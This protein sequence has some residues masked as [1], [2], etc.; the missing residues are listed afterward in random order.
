MNKIVELKINPEVDLLGFEAVALVEQPA[1]EE[2]FYAFKSIDVQDLIVEEIIKKELF[3]ERLPGESKDH[4]I[5]RCIPKLKSEGYADDQAAAICYEGLA[6]ECPPA[7]QD[8]SLNLENRQHAIDTAHYG[9]LNPNE[10][11]EEYWKKKA[12]MFQSDITSAKKALCGNCSFFNQTQKILDCIATGI[13]QGES[14]SDPWSTID[15][16]DLGYC[17][18]FDFK[19]AANRTC[20]AWVVGGPITD[21][22]TGESLQE[23]KISFDF[24]DTLNTPEGKQLASDLIAKG[25]DVYVISAGQHVEEFYPIAD[26]LGIPH[27]KLFATGSNQA[28]IEKI[29]EL[30]IEKHYDNNEDVIYALG[31]IGEQFDLL[32]D[33]LPD[34]INE[35][36]D[37]TSYEFESYVDYPE[38]A[39][40]AAKR[41]LEW[42]DNHPEQGCGTLVGWARANQLAK[43]EPISEETIA[44]MASF[45]RHLQYEDVPYSEGCGGLMVDAWGGR[46]GIEWASR[47]LE[48]LRQ[49]NAGVDGLYYDDLD[50]DTQ[51]AIINALEGIGIA[52]ED[53]VKKGY[54]FN[55][56]KSDANPELPSRDTFGDYKI[57]YKYT[58]PKD[59]KN[60][61]FCARLLSLNL[62]FRKEDIQ[63]LSVKGAN[64]Q[65]GFY[66]IFMYKGSYNCRHE[67]TPVEVYIKDSRDEAIAGIVAGL[68]NT[69][70]SKPVETFSQFKFAA[71]QQILIGPM[72][73]PDKLILRI[74][75]SGNP[76]HIFF[77]R[78]TIKQIAYKMLKEKLI[79]K[80][81][82]EHNAANTVS[83][84]LL[85]SWII[86]DPLKDK[87]TTYGFSLP[88]GTWMAMYKIEDPEVWKRVKAGQVKGFSIEGYFIDQLF[89][90]YK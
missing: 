20:D 18:A 63:K 60:R 89:K 45:A 6:L 28:K 71:D 46:A 3:V 51:D 86:E 66:D 77:S 47:K 82:L 67:W 14:L 9:P 75:D 59:S 68:A 30:G 70:V 57:L 80:V 49:E 5:G 64:E 16:G 74:D 23:G 31:P 27:S 17:E 76:Y 81:N 29:L 10:P 43:R 88:K 52:E 36:A 1:I 39:I 42:K 50:D 48:E 55:V 65:F 44:R 2:N 35:I 79:D 37:K 4:Y 21:E 22:W 61:K 58:G 53:L 13:A 32:V 26:E 41:A 8:I 19:C 12:D 34:Y 69:E 54:Q 11:N 85:E 56:F 7:T 25:F 84:H 62:M 15:A 24:H 73:V 33:T 87:S 83:A 78:E 90:Q 72:M 38:A 40:N